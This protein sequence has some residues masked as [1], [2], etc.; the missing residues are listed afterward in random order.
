MAF[1]TF[2]RLHCHA[3]ETDISVIRKARKKIAKHARRNR[4]FRQ[5]RHEFFR[6]M[7]ATH[8][9]IQQQLRQMRL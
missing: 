4:K 5:A 9:R 1:S 7:L 8:H 6:E 2:L 3:S